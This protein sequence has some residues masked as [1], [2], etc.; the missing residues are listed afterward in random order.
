MCLAIPSKVVEI[1]GNRAIVERFGETLEVYLGLMTEPI[2][3]GDYL[4]LQ[5]RTH[6]VGKLEPEEAKEALRL[7]RELAKRMEHDFN[8]V[9][10]CEVA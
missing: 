3:I 7:F 10:E 5:A 9:T 1:H 6:A 4:I 8:S 2:E